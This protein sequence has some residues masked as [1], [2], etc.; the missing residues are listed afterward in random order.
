MSELGTPV[1]AARDQDPGPVWGGP[2]RGSASGRNQ[3]R[4]PVILA[5]VMV[6][7]LLFLVALATIVAP[8]GTGQETTL[9]IGRGVIVTA[10]GGWTSASDIW[11]VGPGAVSLQ[12]SGALVAFAVEAHEGTDRSL[13]AQQSRQLEQDFDSYRALPAAATVVAGDLPALVV[14]FSGV[15]RSG[16]LE[17]EIVSAVRAGTGVVMLAVAPA[18]QLRRVQGDIDRMLDTMLVPR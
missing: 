3:W 18:G 6:G 17:G 12:K 8:S 2:V 11:E 5:I 4:G 16:S 7:W 9:R 1:Y 10:P 14:L 15:A 13:L